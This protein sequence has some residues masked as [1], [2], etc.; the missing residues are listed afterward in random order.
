ME[1]YLHYNG[2]KTRAVELSISPV[3]QFP[4]IVQIMSAIEIPGLASAD[5]VRYAVL[6]LVSN[7]LRAHREKKIDQVVRVVLSIS[8][9]ELRV[10][11]EDRG[12]GFN[13]EVL[14]YD[15]SKNPELVDPNSES[16]Q[17]Y[18]QR[19]RNERFGM[20]LLSVRRTFSKF[21][22]SFV[23]AVGMQSS[24][25]PEVLGTCIDGEVKLC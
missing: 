22:L 6:E 20:G 8:G 25:S 16:F 19:N 4:K 9:T 7:S 24:W 13:P 10:Q 3:T 21:R 1:T 5:L 12:G 23:T 11:V 2:K 18:R 15:F 17:A 14:P